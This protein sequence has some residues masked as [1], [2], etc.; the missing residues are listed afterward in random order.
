MTHTNK[1]E[2]TLWSNMQKLNKLISTKFEKY[3]G[4]GQSRL[5]IL[6][7]LY[8]VVEMSQTRLQKEVNI[9]HA[10]ITRHLKQ[11]ETS[12]LVARRKSAEDH[13]ITLVCLTDEGRSKILLYQNEKDQFIQQMLSGFQKDEL[14]VLADMVERMNQNIRRF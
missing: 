1:E 9:D 6:H 11:L 13:R 8:Q 14:I 12:G 2:V 7:Q 10:A 4:I 3:T 5:D